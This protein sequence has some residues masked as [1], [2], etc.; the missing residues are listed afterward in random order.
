MLIA[1]APAISAQTLGAVDTDYTGSSSEGPASDRDSVY[2]YMAELNGSVAGGDHT[3][4]WLVN[5]R[6]G[7]S[8]LKKNNGYLRAGAFRHADKQSRWDWDFGVDLVGAAHYT[9]EFVVQQL[10]A[11]VRYRCLDLYIGSKENPTMFL[12]PQLSSG[13]MVQSINARPVPQVRLGVERY[14]Y[15][16]FTKHKLAF[17]AYFA[18]GMFTDQDW[19]YTFTKGEHTRNKRVLYHSKGLFLRW[20]DTQKFPLTVEGGLEM[21]AQWGGEIIYSNGKIVKPGHSFKNFLKAIFPASS[22]STDESLA[23]DVIN[24]EGNHVGQWN[25]AVAWTPKDQDWGARLYYQH[26]FD[27]HS[28]MFFDYL[29]RDMLLGVELQLPKNPFVKKFVYEYLI[30]KDQSGP[31]IWDKTPEIPEQISSGDNYYN[32]FLYNAWQHWGMAIGN[33]LL[34]SPI[35]NTDGVITF[36]NN[37]VKAHHFGFTGEPLRDLDYRVLF[38][39]N[40]SWGTYNFPTPNVTHQYSGLIELNYHPERLKGWGARLSVAADWGNLTGHSSGA[41]LSIIKKGWL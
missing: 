9:S 20:G 8:S 32:N 24:I 25:L 2:S 27:D 41:M 34:T 13:D 7:L 16:P 29:W 33:P 18:M 14:T 4:F 38:S 35:Y 31:V 5:G 10:Y 6:Y 40:R 17:R 30:T 22:S 3:P 12:D 39:Y 21:A 26:F 1:I 23:G 36:Y 19:Q 11:G 15:I 28:M 37:R